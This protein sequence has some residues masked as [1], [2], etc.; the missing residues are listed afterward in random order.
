MSETGSYI[1]EST[2][3]GII[4]RIARQPLEELSKLDLDPLVAE[5]LLDITD[6]DK[7]ETLNGPAF[8]GARNEAARRAKE[9]YWEE[10]PEEA[11]NAWKD[12]MDGK[13]TLGNLASDNP[14]AT[15]RFDPLLALSKALERMAQGAISGMMDVTLEENDTE[16]IEEFAADIVNGPPQPAEP[17]ISIL[18]ETKDVVAEPVADA[19]LM[20]VVKILDEDDAKGSLDD[21]IDITDATQDDL[22]FSDTTHPSGL[23]P[24]PPSED[25]PESLGSPESDRNSQIIALIKQIVTDDVPSEQNPNV[26]EAIHEEHPKYIAAQE[27]A[28][29]AWQAKAD[30]LGLD[31]DEGEAIST[32]A[33]SHWE[34]ISREP[35]YS[36]RATTI[37]TVEESVAQLWLQVEQHL[38]TSM[39]E[40][41][42]E[43]IS[44]QAISA[45]IDQ[46]QNNRVV[47]LSEY[48]PGVNYCIRGSNPLD[49][50]NVQAKYLALKNPS[51]AS[52]EAVVEPETVVETSPLDKVLKA[53]G[54]GVRQPLIDVIDS[55][56]DKNWFFTLWRRLKLDKSDPVDMSAEQRQRIDAIKADK[57]QRTSAIA[58]TKVLGDSYREW[59]T[60]FEQSMNI[61]G[62]DITDYAIAGIEIAAEQELLRQAGAK[63]R[64]LQDAMKT[65]SDQRTALQ[66]QMLQAAL[67]GGELQTLGF[68]G[69]GYGAGGSDKLY[70]Q[71]R[72]EQEAKVAPDPRRYF[73]TKFVVLLNS[74]RSAA[75]ENIRIQAIEDM[76]IYLT[77]SE[78][79]AHHSIGAFANA[80]KAQKA[81]SYEGLSNQ[82]GEMGN[83][84]MVGFHDFRL[85]LVVENGEKREL[86]VLK[87]ADAID[88]LEDNPTLR[89]GLFSNNKK[90]QWHA[91]EVFSDLLIEQ[92]LGINPAEFKA[93]P[94]EFKI[95]VPSFPVGKSIDTATLADID[96]SKM[97]PFSPFK[98]FEESEDPEK[99]LSYKEGGGITTYAELGASFKWMQV[100]AGLQLTALGRDAQY[101]PD[102]IGK[103]L[104]QRR[105]SLRRVN[106]HTTFQHPLPESH[107]YTDPLY[108]D[109]WSENAYKL[110]PTLIATENETRIGEGIA[111]PSKKTAIISERKKAID[112][113][114]MD[115]PLR[116]WLETYM[117]AIAKQE[118]VKIPGDLVVLGFEGR[119]SIVKN[120]KVAGHT[121][122]SVVV[123][124]DT[125]VSFANYGETM[126]FLL[127]NRASKGW[128]RT[129][130]QMRQVVAGMVNDAH[131]QEL[132][133]GKSWQQELQD[134]SVWDDL[135]D[136]EKSKATGVEGLKLVVE[137]Y[138]FSQM[139]YEEGL[140]DYS[141][142]KWYYYQESCKSGGDAQLAFLRAINLSPIR[143]RESALFI[144]PT[145]AAGALAEL[146]KPVS[147]LGGMFGYADDVLGAEFATNWIS[148]TLSLAVDHGPKIPRRRFIINKNT[149]ENLKDNTQQG[150]ITQATSKFHKIRTDPSNARPS[151]G[152]FAYSR[153]KNNSGTSKI[154]R[155]VGPGGHPVLDASDS[156]NSFPV[157][158]QFGGRSFSISALDHVFSAIPG[159]SSIA[160]PVVDEFLKFQY[161][162]YEDRLPEALEMSD[163]ELEILVSERMFHG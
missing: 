114:F 18:D 108:A 120:K 106:Y 162:A 26:D 1:N 6:P 123:A 89:E 7:K 78:R 23:P 70:E 53:V 48:N 100:G 155:L 122:E 151:V 39:D 60:D 88:I 45:V 111:D 43:E 57:I 81:R 124:R 64:L 79:A 143:K 91:E 9:G 112:F 139:N 95:F 29:I 113:V 34:T 116:P 156:Y 153:Y 144:K 2:A 76:P 36:N 50:E 92:T 49:V 3:R 5:R 98:D 87:F 19:Q 28:R 73:A 101:D 63:R 58:T 130:D 71:V 77:D 82:V 117:D 97:V 10:H 24:T 105:P 90:A 52:T 72:T 69:R 27:K 4:R 152:I 13:L 32:A 142:W 75:P 119:N 35:K 134:M 74:E 141:V 11:D 115:K 103:F 145:H 161:K 121:E 148:A 128:L 67:E 118:T 158:E 157:R 61:Y 44:K 46:I 125:S 135:T 80:I 137:K 66:E 16:P 54:I 56:S 136:D 8:V 12:F 93:N 163:A 21:R 99:P 41:M 55:G 159:S 25:P 17:I 84:L 131:F 147:E 109:F 14:N 68:E 154:T 38:P 47:R 15:N 42:R 133:R 107:P 110:I 104:Y 138:S 149:A 85:P 22:S 94:G 59:D 146:T 65:P 160:M 150:G 62:A 129:K 40:L 51:E 127:N 30:E 96:P 102:F 33:L 83:E 37:E 31:P 132:F 86:R 140:D 126:Q 20:E